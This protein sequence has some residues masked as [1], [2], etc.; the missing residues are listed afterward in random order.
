M[1]QREP[2][3]GHQKL[4][5]LPILFES[6]NCTSGLDYGYVEHQAREWLFSLC[7]HACNF[8]GNNLDDCENVSIKS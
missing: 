1:I 4:L 5:K 2:A 3:V 7:T 6:K 8:G